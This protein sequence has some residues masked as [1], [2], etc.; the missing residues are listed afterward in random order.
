MHQMRRAPSFRVIR[1]RPECH[2]PRVALKQRTRFPGRMLSCHQR[3][4]SF[5]AYISTLASSFQLANQAH[6]QIWPRR[7]L[8]KVPCGLFPRPALSRLQPVRTR[9]SPYDC[10][11]DI[12][13]QRAPLPVLARFS[14]LDLSH[15]PEDSSGARTGK[16]CTGCCPGNQCN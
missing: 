3:N 6:N 1:Q 8:T 10:G 11:R 16:G 9:A 2:Q 15:A 12:S 5:S 4:S 7:R 14:L 13:V